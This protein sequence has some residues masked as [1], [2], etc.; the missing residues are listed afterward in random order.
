MALTIL[1]Q[2]TGWRTGI[3]QSFSQ[4]ITGLLEGLAE[5]KTK[6]LAKE[7]YQNAFKVDEETAIALSNLPPQAQQEWIKNYVAKGGTRA[8]VGQK[9]AQQA[10]AQQQQLA[11]QQGTQEPDVMQGL[12]AEQQGAQEPDIMQGLQTEQQDLNQVMQN[13]GQADGAAQQGVEQQY[14]QQPSMYPKG[15]NPETMEYDQPAENVE[16]LLARPSAKELQAKRARQRAE[17][18]LQV[19]KGRLAES[20]RKTNL[21]ETRKAR[22]Q[23][24]AD[25]T[26]A[27]ERRPILKKMLQLSEQDKLDSPYYVKAL[28]SLGLDDLGAALT[29]IESEQYQALQG[30]FLKDLKPIFGRVTEGEMKAYEKR[31]PSLMNTKEGRKVIF[32]DMLAVNKA[33][34]IVGKKY[35]EIMKENNYNPPI[36]IKSLAY[37]RAKPQ[38]D[39]IYKDTSFGKLASLRGQVLPDKSEFLK[40]GAP[41]IRDTNTGQ[42]YILKN[43]KYVK[44][45]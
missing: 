22:E 14:E 10:Q 4:G 39:Q 36:N 27:K 24:E 21:Q 2:Q 34:I 33:K 43:G 20:Q 35:D 15:F 28:K 16:E 31:L 29:N 18:G 30:E 5:Q 41:R 19:Q 3:G 23:I 26:Q 9:Q 44:E 17:E 8:G 13:L 32:K 7:A 40:A 12:Q 42:Y 1:P 38:I 37:E 6:R 11:Q 25:S 45:K